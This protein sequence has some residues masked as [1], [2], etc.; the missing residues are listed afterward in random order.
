VSLFNNLTYK[1]VLCRGYSGIWS[2]IAFG[3]LFEIKSRVVSPLLTSS[4]LVF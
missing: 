4:R 2:D 3:H 1:V